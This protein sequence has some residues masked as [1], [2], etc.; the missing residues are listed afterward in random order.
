VHALHACSAPF[1]ITFAS[2][3]TMSRSSSVIGRALPTFGSY[4]L[5]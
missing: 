4:Q 1:T 3:E 2:R 5:L